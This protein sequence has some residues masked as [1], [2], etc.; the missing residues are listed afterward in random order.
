VVESG[1]DATREAFL[2]AGVRLYGSMSDRVLRGFTAGAVSDEAGFRRQTF[3]RY[4]DTQADYVRDLILHL[5]TD[6]EPAADGTAVLPSRRG[7]NVDW[8]DLGRD[9]ARYDYRRMASDP[10]V[11]MRVGL[12]TMQAAAALGLR[13]EIRDYYDHVNQRMAAAM[14]AILDEVGRR[15]RPP[16]TVRDL[17]RVQQAL[18]VGLVVLE[19]AE[20]EDEPAGR[21][22][23]AEIFTWIGEA[24]TE[25]RKSGDD[26]SSES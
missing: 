21:D 1:R 20:M 15:A 10:R 11:R 3:Y 7:S 18:L 6:R 13:Q 25:Q 2:A 23:Y 12:A 22:I 4:W 9:I 26:A 5:L 14:Q 24:L 8:A 19:M 17:A 16:L